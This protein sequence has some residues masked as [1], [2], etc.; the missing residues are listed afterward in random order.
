MKKEKPTCEIVPFPRVIRRDSPLDRLAA[1]CK[2]YDSG[3]Y[4]RYAAVAI[5]KNGEVE[6]LTL[7]DPCVYRD[8]RHRRLVSFKT[9]ADPLAELE[10]MRKRYDDGEYQRLVVIGQTYDHQVEKVEL[11]PPISYH[12]EAVS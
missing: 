11:E 4:R 6:E 12:L 3:E 8:R 7:L 9:A 5:K 2:K 10:A 1:M